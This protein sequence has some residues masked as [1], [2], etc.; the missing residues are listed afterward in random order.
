MA[1]KLFR[2][3]LFHMKTRVSLRYFVTIGV[4]KRLEW[5]NKVNFKKSFTSLCGYHF[6]Q[7][8]Q[9]INQERCIVISLVESD[10]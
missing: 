2:S 8:D 1:M 4:K 6:V 7:S 9:L 5:K 10:F 3:V